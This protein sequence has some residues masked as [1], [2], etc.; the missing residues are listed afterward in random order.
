MEKTEEHLHSFPFCENID[1]IEH[2]Y[3]ITENANHSYGL[4]KDGMLIAEVSNDC[5][6]RRISGEALE[7]R[8]LQKICDRIEDHYT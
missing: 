3:R 5:E 2:T 7:E 1:G 8:L 6:R 4:E